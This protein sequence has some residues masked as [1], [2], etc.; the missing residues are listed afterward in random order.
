MDMNDTQR[1]RFQLPAEQQA[2][3]DKCFHPS[4]T[5]VEFPIEDV[6][7]SIPA[8][9]EK[10]V[11]MCPDRL[12]IKM[13]N[14]ALTYDELNKAANRIAWAIL[15]RCGERREPIALLFAHDIEVVCAI[16]GVLKAGKFYIALDP[17]VPLQR[18]AYILDETECSWILTN[19]RKLHLV[20]QLLGDTR[21]MI[22]I[23]ELPSSLPFEEPKIAVS[24]DDLSTITYTS[25]ST[26]NPKGVIETHRCRLHNVMVFTNDPHHICADDRLSLIHSVSFASGEI[27]LYRALLNGAALLPFDLRFD[28]IER[29]ASWLREEKITVCHLPVAVFSEL[30]NL[31]THDCSFPD[32]RIVHLSGSPIT[33]KHFELYKQVFASGS[34][35]ALHMGSTETL[36]ICT[37]VVDAKFKFPKEGTLAGY[38]APD[39][40]VV[41]LDDAGKE[42]GRDEVGE[43]AVKSRYMPR[44]YWR[45]SQPDRYRYLPD[46][47]GGAE[48]IYMTGD[49]GRMLPDGFMIHLG[50]KDHMV[51][52]RGYRVNIGE[53]ERVLAEHSKVKNAAVI[54]RDLGSGEKSLIGYLVP[55][56]PP[57]PTVS[58][59][60]HFL[61]TRI[62][63]YM[64][65]SIYVFLDSLPLVNGKLDRTRLPVPELKRPQLAERYV[66]PGNLIERM[67]ERIWAEALGLD[68]VGIHDNFF[69]L[70]G[71]SLTTTRV[72]SQ[73]IRQFRF[74]LPIKALFQSP[75]VAEMAA[76]IMQKETKWA[77]EDALNRMLSEVE[78]MT[79]EEAQKQLAGESGRS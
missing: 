18:L 77:S 42:A 21:G 2:I 31:L 74:E 30:A 76:I 52:I 73:V 9:F 16:L 54:A 6:E 59:I 37:A 58:E 36:V 12:A 7:T 55:L 70:G 72:V 19:E 11:G 66:A 45:V 69:D 32:L 78:A 14:R 64:I 44:G 23:D 67:L 71:H 47:A 5:F 39:K 29:L 28:G 46:L 22:N 43:I 10:I 15:E 17:S 79:E 3:R 38:P 56:A 24:P 8:R 40:H 1:Q 33:R 60:N 49:L 63:D 51:K 68:C 61:R 27:Q 57:P 53:A 26:G 35:L 13:G 50:R 65:P 25:G 62:P 75:T 34:L 4:G 48:Q 20:R 41:L